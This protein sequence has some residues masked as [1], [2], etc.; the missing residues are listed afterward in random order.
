MSV[1]IFA[2]DFTLDGSRSSSN[3]YRKVEL[4]SPADL[5]YLIAKVSRTAQEKINKHFPPDAA[6]QGEDRMRSRVEMLV[7]DYIRTVFNL[8]KPNLSINGMDSKEI[9]AE[10]AKAQEGEGMYNEGVR[11]RCSMD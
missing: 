7:D 2:H 11:Q 9:D 6:V 5:T 10:L 4:Q 8:A 1:N 3:A